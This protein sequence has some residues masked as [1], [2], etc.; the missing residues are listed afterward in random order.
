MLFL[1]IS[2]QKADMLDQL[3]LTNILVLDIETVPQ[4]AHFG[5][6]PVQWQHLWYKKAQFLSKKDD[7]GHVELY[8]R[9]G[10]YAEFGKVI[11]ISVGYFNRSGNQWQ[12]RVK[13]FY[14][15][16][17]KLVLEE[18]SQL[19]ERHFND[20]EHLLCAHNGKEFDFPYLCR[21]MMINNLTIPQNLN[22]AGKKPW[23]VKHI[24]TMELWKFG[25]FKNFTSLELLAASFDIPTPKDDIDGSMVWKVYWEE[26]N[27]ERIATYC[28]KDVVT[29]AQLLL[30][31]KHL[32]LLDESDIIIS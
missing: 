4:Y 12:F 19:L 18:F 6:M 25:D 24:D 14:G 23:E 31:F 13:A 32:P 22:V 29:V 21:R 9:A 1:V 8:P 5:D 10:I 3:E 28:K 17:E 15:D 30:R 26:K 16:N 11:C 7:A 20:Q 27:L 2:K